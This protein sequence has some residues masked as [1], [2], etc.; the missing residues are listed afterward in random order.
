M[1][2]RG[3]HV[4]HLIYSRRSGRLQKIGANV[5]GRRRAAG[6]HR[7]A[8]VPRD[9]HPVRRSPPS[10][11]CYARYDRRGEGLSHCCADPACALNA[12]W[13]SPSANSQPARRQRRVKPKPPRERVMTWSRSRQYADRTP[14]STGQCASETS[15][16]IPCVRFATWP[17][18]PPAGAVFSGRVYGAIVGGSAPA[19]SFARKIVSNRVDDGY[20]GSGVPLQP[21][22][23]RSVPAR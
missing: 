4:G 12:N 22:L 6:A 14:D 11:P 20:S 3:L 19:Q 16:R 2:R 17:V 10:R 18:E 8:R 9:E 1:V 23:R 21:H 15:L 7:L 5:R 13:R